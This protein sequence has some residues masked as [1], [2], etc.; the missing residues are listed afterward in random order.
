MGCFQVGLL[1]DS[2]EAELKEKGRADARDFD[3]VSI[4]FT[5][6]KGFTA[7]S[8][9]LNAQKLVAEINYLLRSI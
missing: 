8:E 3:L 1:T 5:D 7:A 9:K 2:V 4:L 6:F